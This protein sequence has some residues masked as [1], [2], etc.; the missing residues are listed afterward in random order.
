MT[1]IM[2]TTYFDIKKQNS[3][4]LFMIIDHNYKNFTNNDYNYTSRMIE[5]LN[6]CQCIWTFGLTL[7]IV[8]H[9]E[10]NIV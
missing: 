10:Q 5:F 1:K 2:S 4:N 7:L 8:Q 3:L 9:T 6:S